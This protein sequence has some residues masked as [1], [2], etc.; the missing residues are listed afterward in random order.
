[1][2]SDTPDRLPRLRSG[3]RHRG[4]SVTRLEAFVDAAFAFAVTLLV[5]SIDSIPDSLPALVTALKGVPA[6]AASFAMVAMF[7]AAHARWS[8]HYGL[9]DAVSTLLSL[10][11][12]F[13]VLVYVYPLKMLFGTFFAWIS[14]GW[15]PTPIKEVRGYSD[16]VLMFVIY[17]VV[18]AT[19][20]LL[21]AGLYLHAWRQRGELQLDPE[22]R[23]RTGGEIAPFLW[24]ACVGALSTLLTWLLPQMG[25]WLSGLPGLTYWLLAFT[26]FAYQFGAS[27]AQRREAAA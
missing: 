13:L 2:D 27:R 9:D 7:W 11:L 12:V 10:A 15:M 23:R 3:F 26:G 8:R 6:F 4:R 21:T 1:M 24:F 14:Q 19:L 17:G 25:G 18:F 20:A 22:E 16:I 5:I